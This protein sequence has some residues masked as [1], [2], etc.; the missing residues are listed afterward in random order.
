[1]DYYFDRI[2]PLFE[3]S[4]KSDAQLEREIGIPPKKIGQWNIGYTKSYTRYIAKIAAYFH[5]S[6]DYL[7]GNTDDPRP[8]DEKREEPAKAEPGEPSE[9]AIL[10]EAYK[11]APENIQEA[12]R[13]LLGLK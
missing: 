7:L 6:T 13:N 4:G 11:A 2:N 9:D 10:F 5:V 8:A 3:Q 1:M 12:I